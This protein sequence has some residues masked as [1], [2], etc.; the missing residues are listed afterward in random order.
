MRNN[1]ITKEDALTFYP[2]LNEE[3][4]KL[5]KERYA[6]FFSELGYE[7]A[8]KKLGLNP[9]EQLP[10]ANPQTKRQRKLNAFTELDIQREAIGNHPGIKE[11]KWYP[12]FKVTETG[13]VFSHTGY[14]FWYS[15]S[16]AYVGAPFVFSTSD[17]AAEFGKNNVKEYNEIFQ[18]KAYQI[19]W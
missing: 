11:T 18:N 14:G 15:S 10:Y 2:H 4:K 1:E 16:S 9:K 6:D 8:C 12:V 3:G 19:T 17:E 5:F 7:A 13:L